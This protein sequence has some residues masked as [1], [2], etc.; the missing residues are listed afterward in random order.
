[1]KKRI[2]GS[3]MHEQ[4]DR[5]RRAVNDSLYDSIFLPLL[6]DTAEI[7]SLKVAP[8]DPTGL[9]SGYTWELKE[10]MGT[11]FVLNRKRRRFPPDGMTL[12]EYSALPFHKHLYCSRFALWG[13]HHN[14]TLIAACLCVSSCVTN[15]L[16]LSSLSHQLRRWND[17]F[18]GLRIPFHCD[19]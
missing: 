14:D 16:S 2:S 13:L 6:V 15:F 18:S 5:S 10:S 12:K 1:M 4:T 19:W 17:F 9:I 8:S 7:W 11:V 3:G